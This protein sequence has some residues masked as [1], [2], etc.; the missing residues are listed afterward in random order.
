MDGRS[1]AL[2]LGLA[3]AAT[4]LAGCIENPGWLNTNDVEVSA[5]ANRD[6]A[7]DAALQWDSDAVL[8][9]VMAFEL[10]ESEDARIDADPDP[11]NGLA[12]AWWYVYSAK[13]E[14]DASSVRAFKVS[15]D[16]TLTSEDEAEAFAAGMDH[17][18]AE[19]IHDWNADSDD[20]I[21]AAKTDEKFRT[22][23]EGF[24][25]T[26]VEGVARIDGVS[27]W[28]VSAMSADGFVVAMV[29]A[30]TGEL[31]SVQPMDLDFA[32]PSFQW[33]AANPAMIMPPVHVEGEGKLMAGEMAE[34]PFSVGMPMGGI[35]EASTQ[36]MT[37][38]DGLHWAILDDEGEEVDGGYIGSRLT[39]DKADPYELDL[40]A[41]EYTLVISYG[42]F[43][44]PTP[45]DDGAQYAFVLHLEPGYQHEEHAEEH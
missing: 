15:A 27:Q 42:S 3:L 6:L 26:V 2:T 11:G 45:I 24:N 8:V 39:G 4:G 44:V 10:S 21:R 17:N 43:L 40:D 35:L 18:M 34:Y 33:G 13:G 31:L 36:S 25:A 38:M 9:G 22:V 7:Q 29:D 12:P 32:M 41:G 19:G 16:G 5:F 37:P 20:A 23:A 28:W 1:Y 30:N 14:G